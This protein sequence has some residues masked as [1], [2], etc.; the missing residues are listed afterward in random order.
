VKSEPP[1]LDLKHIVLLSL[2]TRPTHV[3]ELIKHEAEMAGTCDA[4]MDGTGG[5]WIGY[6]LQPTIWRL[7]W[8]EEVVELYQ[9]GK[10]TNSDLEMAGVLLQYLVAE[11]LRPMEQCHTAIWS[12]NTPAVNWS[13]KMA[14][15][16]TT[17]IAGQLL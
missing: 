3:T 2:A 4:S 16:A 10:L 7:K 11:R 1:F 17:P 14:D 15:K 5:I 13:T 8:L 6:N 9:A 12:D